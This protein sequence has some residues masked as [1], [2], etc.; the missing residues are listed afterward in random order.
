MW[1]VSPTKAQ[2]QTHGHGRKRKM[3]HY[4]CLPQLIFEI[5]QDG[6]AMTIIFYFKYCKSKVTLGLSDSG[7]ISCG[8]TLC[9]A[10]WWR[11]GCVHESSLCLAEAELNNSKTE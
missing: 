5:F 9:L 2:S 1:C 6:I 7:T 4:H 11:R 8:N 3:I 10:T